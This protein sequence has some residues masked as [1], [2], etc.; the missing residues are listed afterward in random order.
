MFKCKT[1]LREERELAIKS[2][3][4]YPKRLMYGCMKN[5]PSFPPPYHM[6][7]RKIWSKKLEEN[8][9]HCMR[10]LVF[11]DGSSGLKF[12]KPLTSFSIAIMFSSS[13]LLRAGNVSRM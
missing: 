12:S 11:M 3:N 8:T 13:L 2:H 9:T 7:E 1:D 10:A 5:L 6:D 4:A